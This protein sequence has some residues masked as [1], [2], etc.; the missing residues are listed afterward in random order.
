MQ[1]WAAKIASGDVRALAQAATAVENHSPE[2]AG[3]LNALG[4][5]PPGSVTVGVTGPPGAGKSSLV[6]AMARAL[7]RAGKT[8]GIVAVDPSSRV[9]GGAILG[10]RIR[11]QTHHDDPGIYHTV[12][13]HARCDGRA[14]TVDSESG[15]PHRRVRKRFRDHRNRGRGPG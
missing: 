2:A 5:A 8:V 14:G 10:D 13:G 7:R 9:T 11:M 6:D 12:D 1:D 4:P 15:T 3:L